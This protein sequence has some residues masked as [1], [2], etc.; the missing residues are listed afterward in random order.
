M[1]PWWNSPPGDP[2]ARLPSY[3]DR[4]QSSGLARY[5]AERRALTPPPVVDMPAGFSP[6][7]GTNAVIVQAAAPKTGMASPEPPPLAVGTAPPPSRGEVPQYPRAEPAHREVTDAVAKAKP[8]RQA[9]APVPQPPP[10]ATAQPAPTESGTPLNPRI[11]NRGES[12]LE[13]S[14]PIVLPEAPLSPSPT[15]GQEERPRVVAIGPAAAKLAI[16]PPQTSTE[17]GGGEK[18]LLVS[19]IDAIAGPTTAT[20]VTVAGLIVVVI[21]AFAWVRRRERTELGD[22]PAR[23]L[24]SVS[25]GGRGKRESGAVGRALALANA[26][27]VAPHNQSTA[28]TSVPAASVPPGD[29][30]PS[31]RAEALRVLGI[32]V[33][34]D[35]TETAIKKIV[36]GLRL[37]WHPDYAKDAEDLRVRELRLKQI[38]AAWE[39]IAGKRV[40]V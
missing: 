29:A 6:M 30:I 40:A 28:T 23:D 22:A 38:N 8:I 31:S 33:T 5:C 32:G 12:A 7:L 35:A 18:L 13:A 14:S 19:L 16:A 25:L 27:S 15:K 24:A 34:P 1:G 39:I 17:G 26:Q 9:N 20:L 11:I 3:D 10:V 21:A 37:S 2:C 4:W 36:D